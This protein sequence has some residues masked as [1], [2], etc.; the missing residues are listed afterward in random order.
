MAIV[1]DRRAFSREL[2]R[3]WRRQTAFDNHYA[4]PTR[5][6]FELTFT[7]TI[8]D[9]MPSIDADFSHVTYL[10][11][12]GSGPV[13]G[14]NEFLQNF[15]RLRVL[16]LQGF[17]LDAV[18]ES[19]PSMQNLTELYLEDSNIT[20]TPTAAQA[21]SGL[22]N[23]EHIDLD[24]NPLNLTPDFSNMQHLNSVFLSNTELSEFPTSLLGLPEIETID[25]SD[26]LIIDLPSELFE[27]PAFITEALDLAGNPL[28]E[29]SL[30]QA[31]TYFSQTGI[32][33]N[34]SF[35]D[36]DPVAVDIVEPEQ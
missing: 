4:D 30:N 12:R 24:G 27:A 14:V 17:A 29:A 18:P 28:S 34:I 31:H 2:E 13:T 9:N 10:S 35:D 20:L 1:Q 23:L 11:L 19:L 7:R 33:M 21:L 22:E 16:K 26:N 5:D 8:L 25:L 32:D 36:L 15:P 3:C 6:G